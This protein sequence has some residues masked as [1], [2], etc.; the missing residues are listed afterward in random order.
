[1]DLSDDL[2]L[3]SPRIELTR[4][5][6]REEN[7]ME[8]KKAPKFVT[9]LLCCSRVLPTDQIISQKASPAPAKKICGQLI[10]Y[11]SW[12]PS[13]DDNRASFFKKFFWKI[14]MLAIFRSWLILLALSYQLM[15]LKKF[16]RM[17]KKKAQK[18]SCKQLAISAETPKVHS[19]ELRWKKC[20]EFFFKPIS[21]VSRWCNRFASSSRIFFWS[22][23]DVSKF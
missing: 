23:A 19:L 10:W 1:M 6:S 11:F 15:H 18:L 2:F 20:V 9:F 4:R 17:E 7:R 14:C 16:H 21:L 3:F 13:A 8:K 22:E 12:K 5:T